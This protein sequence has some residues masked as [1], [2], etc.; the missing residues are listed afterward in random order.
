[1]RIVAFALALLAAAGL[2]NAA[3][4]PYAVFDW[5]DRAGFNR[6]KSEILSHWRTNKALRV[7]IVAPE[8]VVMGSSRALNGLDPAHAGFA[9]LRS[10]NFALPGATPCDLERYLGLALEAGP[11]K[12]VV[13]GLDMFAA[14]AF[15]DDP[16]C[17]LPDEHA[18]PRIG[19]SRMLFSAD[20]LNAAQKTVLKQRRQDPNIWQPLPNGFAYVP[21]ETVRKQ[22]GARAAMRNFERQT[23]EHFFLPAPVCRFALAE[24]AA[25][26][27]PGKRLERFLAA[28]HDRGL[29]VRLFVSPAHARL[30]LAL[31]AAGLWGEFEAWKR[32][33]VAINDSVARDRGR[34]PFPLWDFSGFNA[35]TTEAVPPAGDLDAVMRYYW[36]ASHY[37]KEA[38][39]LVLDRLLDVPGRAVPEGFGVALTPANLDSHL[40]R[41]RAARDAYRTANPVDAGE[42]ADAARTALGRAVCPRRG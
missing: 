23:L 36:D 26:L 11:L 29:D 5:I 39:D 12:R 40:A 35:V 7:R 41:T 22:G 25:G 42:A 18:N 31:D 2:F 13:V 32:A 17:V 37:R 1:M 34:T 4:D 3:V 14:N 16:R 20:T 15:L 38:G 8:A 19:F 24:P 27:D 30:A 9:G 28:A 6:Y 21:V 10:Y 33:L